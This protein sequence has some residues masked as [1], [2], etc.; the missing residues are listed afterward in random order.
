MENTNVTKPRLPLKFKPKHVKAYEK[1]NGSIMDNLDID[2]AKLTALIQ[3]G[4]AMCEEEV[5]DD[6]L[7][8]FLDN[9]GDTVECL[10]QIVEAL[11]SG[12]F[13]PRDLAI[14]KIMRANVKNTFA[15]LETKLASQL[16]KTLEPVPEM[17]LVS[18]EE[19]MNQ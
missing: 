6:I 10:M 12:G 2:L 13:L 3:C 19:V 11:Q 5:A 14:A 18:I 9:G 16:E 17:E 8:T 15:S 1:V 4:N 7:E